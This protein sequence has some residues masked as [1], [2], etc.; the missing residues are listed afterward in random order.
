MSVY[1]LNEDEVFIMRAPNVT[2][3]TFG[4]VEL[5]L[6]SK[7]IIQIN[8]GFL[9]GDKGAEKYPLASLKVY[10]GKANIVATKNKAGRRQIELFFC[11]FEKTYCFDNVFSQ[12]KWVAEVK[13]AHKQY[14]EDAEKA[15]KQAAEKGNIIK[16]LTNSAKN[17]IPKRELT[18]QQF[19]C[20][21][22]G[23]DLRGIKGEMIR[24]EYCDYEN[25]VN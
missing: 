1:T 11:G 16:S 22:C 19:K 8:K 5:V 12:N 3:G 13:K 24:C 17:I 10:N 23:A 4:K 14:L 15:R 7:N 18:C 9:G 20:E 21:K 25:T 6:T 2:V